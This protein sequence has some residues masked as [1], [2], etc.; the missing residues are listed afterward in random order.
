[1]EERNI[2]M[3]PSD[4]LQTRLKWL[5]VKKW[6]QKRGSRVLKIED[7][8]SPLTLNR[9]IGNSQNKKAFMNRAFS[10]VSRNMNKTIVSDLYINISLIIEIIVRSYAKWKLLQTNI[11][12]P[13]PIIYHCP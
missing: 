6:M 11:F 8:G 12:L 10:P 4:R 13:W 9:T 1:M 7:I 2:H 5:D 3:S